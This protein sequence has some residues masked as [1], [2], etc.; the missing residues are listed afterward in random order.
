MQP[1]QTGGR[2]A[3][4]RTLD[5]LHFYHRALPLHNSSLSAFPRLSTASPGLTEAARHLVL[6]P[7]LPCLPG[8]P[9][10]TSLVS[11]KI[12]FK[13]TSKE[14]IGED[15]QAINEAIKRGIRA[16]AGAGSVSPSCALYYSLSL[17]LSLSRSLALSRP[18]VRSHPLSLVLFL[19]LSL[20]SLSLTLSLL[21]LSHPL[22]L[23]LSL[24]LS[25]FLPPCRTFRSL[26]LEEDPAEAT[27]QGEGGPQA[28][29]REVRRERRD[30]AARRAGEATVLSLKAVITAFPSVSL[31][32]LAVP[33]RSQPTVALRP[34]RPSGRPSAPGPAAP[35]R[36]RPRQRAVRCRT[37]W[38][39]RRRRPRRC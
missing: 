7:A 6:L 37:S 1:C 23:S 27:E 35:P 14:Y 9:Q 2:A 21:S 8:L 13:G 4:Q 15:A 18:L 22:S 31:P 39:W 33:L 24:S 3:S 12:P 34:P 11:T 16:C 5:L 26:A 30:R 19:F 20:S 28:Q 25:P 36:R 32:F 17:S 38:R 10:V 29:P